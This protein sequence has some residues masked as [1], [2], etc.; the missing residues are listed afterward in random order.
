L[1]R[2]YID[3]K[4]DLDLAAIGE[5]TLEAVTSEPESHARITL[6]FHSDGGWY[7][8]GNGVSGEGW[9]TLRF[10]KASFS[11]EDSPAGWHKVDQIRIAVWRGQ[12]QDFAIRFRR[13]AGTWH[14]VA[15]VVPGDRT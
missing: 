3:R 10:P 14:D 9:K 11:V 4:V 7:G 2:V 13:L 12:D 5:F 8:A 15:L 6:Y 1:G